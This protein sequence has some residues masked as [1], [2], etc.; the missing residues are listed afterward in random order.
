MLTSDGSYMMSV[1]NRKCRVIEDVLV[2][3][4]YMYR[5]FIDVSK[6]EQQNI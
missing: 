3:L 4:I 6:N 1:A 5:L 2:P